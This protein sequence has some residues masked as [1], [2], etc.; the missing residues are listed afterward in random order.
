MIAIDNDDGVGI[1][2]IDA[3]M[4]KQSRTNLALH[5]CKSEV[6]S[7]VVAED[8]LRVGRTQHAFGIEQ[9]DR[10]PVSHGGAPCDRCS[11]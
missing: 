10:V 2:G 3:V 7:A 5:G 8:E 4:A 9:N 1:G 11:G 6:T